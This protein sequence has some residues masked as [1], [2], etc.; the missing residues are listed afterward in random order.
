MHTDTIQHNKKYRF[1]IQPSLD[2]VSSSLREFQFIPLFEEAAA[3]SG[4]Q[5]TSTARNEMRHLN[6]LVAWEKELVEEA[7][8]SFHERLS[9]ASAI[10]SRSLQVGVPLSLTTALSEGY[11][12]WLSGLVCLYQ[13]RPERLILHVSASEPV[14][15]RD[16][17]D[18]F[19]F[20]GRAGFKICVDGYLADGPFFETLS[21]PDIHFINCHN[22]LPKQAVMSTLAWRYV[23]GLVAL[24][25]QLDKT[26]IL[27]G[28]DTTGDLK[29]VSGLGGV[30][31]QGKAAGGYL[32]PD[33]LFTSIDLLA[34]D[35]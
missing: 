8:V 20:L 23:S 12:E 33:E 22:L 11:L 19:S 21:N 24:A 16:A 4:E 35:Q 34:P 1:V 29:L 3:T 5:K 28:I 13:I 14:F 31:F 32:A 10:A 15:S 6:N 17:K 26:V 9:S 25:K 2:A 7:L 30:W 18:V 27:T